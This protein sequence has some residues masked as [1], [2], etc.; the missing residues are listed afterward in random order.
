MG[1]YVAAAAIVG[2]RLGLEGLVAVNVGALAVLLG[3]YLSGA[4]RRLRVA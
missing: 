4:I 1:T 3:L 2:P